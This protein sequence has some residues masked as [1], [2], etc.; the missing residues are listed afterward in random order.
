MSN[1]SRAKGS[2]SGITKEEVKELFNALSSQME[3]RLTE[4]VNSNMDTLLRTVDEKLDAKLRDTTNLPQRDSQL[5]EREIKE[6]VED[7]VKE[8]LRASKEAETRNQRQAFGQV[9]KPGS[10]RGLCPTVAAAKKNVNRV[11]PLIDT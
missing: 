3:D 7:A 11:K 4:R 9:S 8:S 1:R 6:L 10:G 5:A 2:T